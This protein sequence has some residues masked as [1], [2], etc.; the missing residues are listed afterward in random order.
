MV[1][2]IG[3]ANVMLTTV[4]NGRFLNAINIEIKATKPARHLFK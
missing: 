1:V 4:A 2:K 3:A